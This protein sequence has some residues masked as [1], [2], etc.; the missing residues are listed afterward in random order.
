MFLTM[1]PSSAL[2]IWYLVALLD[3]KPEINGVL[4]LGNA[5]ELSR[6]WNSQAPAREGMSAND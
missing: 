1:Q 3:L 5:M 6:V 4:D 2:H